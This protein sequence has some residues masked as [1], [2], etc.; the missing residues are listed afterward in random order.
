MVCEFYLSKKAKKK[1]VNF[2]ALWD[3]GRKIFW[4]QR[5]C[6]SDLKAYH[7]KKE[8]PLIATLAPSLPSD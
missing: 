7:T 1:K 4:G 2:L 6:L 5:A 3:L 8:F